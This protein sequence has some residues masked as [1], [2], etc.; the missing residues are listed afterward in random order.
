MTFYRGGQYAVPF[1]D[2]L[3]DGIVTPGAATDVRI[4]IGS[5]LRDMTSHC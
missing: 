5:G 3:K 4:Q 2:K 1:V